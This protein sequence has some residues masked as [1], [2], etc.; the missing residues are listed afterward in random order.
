MN[1]EMPQYNKEIKKW[2]HILLDK[3]FFDQSFS[4]PD[5]RLSAEEAY[6]FSRFEDGLS[7]EEFLRYYQTSRKTSTRLLNFLLKEKYLVKREDP[8]DKRRR[9]LILTEKGRREKEKLSGIIHETID[10]IL[11]DFTVNEEIAV[12]KFVSRINQLTVDK[13]EMPKGD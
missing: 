7:P 13:F 6:I 12:L 3:V 8:E 9:E 2:I 10:M 1:N 5:S 11:S 4:D